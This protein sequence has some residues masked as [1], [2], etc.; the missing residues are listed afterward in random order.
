MQRYLFTSG[1]GMV[2][3]A[4][5]ER[6]KAQGHHITILT[7]Q[8]KESHDAQIDYINWSKDGWE[9]QVPDIDVV[10]NLAGASLMQRWTKENKQSIMLSR[11][12]STEALYELFANRKQR[13]DVLF[14]A[15]AVGAY[16]PDTNYTYT[17]EYRT[18][19]FDF[20]SDVVYQWERHARKFEALGTRVIMGRFGIILSDQG[21]SLP[22]MTMPYKYFVGGKLGSGRQWYSWIHIDDLVRG[23]LHVIEDDSAE[24]VFNMTAPMPERQNLFGYTLGR[25]MNRPHY[26]WVPAIAMK[27]VMGQMA[28]VVLDTQKVLPNKL[29]AHGFNFK[30]ANLKVALEDLLG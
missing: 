15:S 16:P 12:K 18:L 20:L 21:G 25:V 2:G 23:A 14:N 27:A 4:I 13:P 24:G 28:T 6:V 30:Y 7:R 26:T 19:P 3:S 22:L 1:T 8:D 5:V 29:Q 10:V 17:E 9:Q 11:M